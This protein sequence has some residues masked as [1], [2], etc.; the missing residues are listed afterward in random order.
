MQAVV[1]LEAMMHYR[2]SVDEL[3]NRGVGAAGEVC[4]CVCVCVFV[5]VCVCGGG[6]VAHVI[7]AFSGD[8]WAFPF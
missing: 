7:L 1:E 8:L 5:C 6:M 4:L 2:Q 3:F